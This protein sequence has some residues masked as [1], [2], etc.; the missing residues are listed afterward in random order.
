MRVIESTVIVRVHNAIGE[1]LRVDLRIID[2]STGSS[3]SYTCSWK[4]Y[5]PSCHAS[6]SSWAH[7]KLRWFATELLTVLQQVYLSREN[8]MLVKSI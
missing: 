1:L 7:P 2:P 3:I 4:D 5:D 8:K 6:W